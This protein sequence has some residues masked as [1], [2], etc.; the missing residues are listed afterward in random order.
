MDYRDHR[1]GQSFQLEQDAVDFRQVIAQGAGVLK[2]VLEILEVGA[3]AEAAALAPQH[4]RLDGFIP[5]YVVQGGR[6]VGY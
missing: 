1:E 3:G 5:G 4:Q 6:Q 2:G